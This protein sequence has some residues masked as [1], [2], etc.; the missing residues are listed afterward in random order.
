MNIY[1]FIHLRGRAI[2]MWFKQK[3]QLRV[4][5]VLITFILLIVLL[6]FTNVATAGGA[7]LWLEDAKQGGLVPY[8]AL[9][10]RNRSTHNYMINENSIYGSQKK[11][12]YLLCTVELRTLHRHHL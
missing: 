8:R 2:N 7:D 12:F 6:L 11:I 10:E 3:N 9:V 4:L 5:C 1:F